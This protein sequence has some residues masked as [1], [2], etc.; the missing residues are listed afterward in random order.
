MKKIPQIL[1]LIGILFSYTITAQVGIGT[2]S[3]HKS[4]IMEV[5][6]SNRGVLIPRVTALQRSNITNPSEGLMVFCT[7]CCG[8]GSLTFFDDT[9]WENTPPCPDLDWDNDGI[10][11]SL[12][13]DD[14][15]DG[16]P[17]GQEEIAR[18]YLIQTFTFQAG[19][20]AAWLDYTGW[21]KNLPID[22]IEVNYYHFSTAINVSFFGGG[23]AGTQHNVLVNNV[24][25]IETQNRPITG[26][27][28]GYVGDYITTDGNAI[29][30]NTTNPNYIVDPQTDNV[31]GLP[32]IKII[33]KVDSTT[34]ILGTLKP[35]DTELVSLQPVNQT[36]NSL[37]PAM[38][39]ANAQ[40]PLP[41]ADV[42]RAGVHKN[43][44]T[45]NTSMKLNF[46]IIYKP[47]IDNDGIVNWKDSDGDGCP[48]VQE[49][50]FSLSAP[51]HGNFIQHLEVGANGMIDIME[52]APESGSSKINRPHPMHATANIFG[53]AIQTQKVCN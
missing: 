45:T 26:L 53:W 21:I 18:G 35:T 39:T 23:A 32:R 25:Y 28:N 41:T 51:P 15:N 38:L 4:A 27:S 3:P 13:V 19:D 10:V 2:T 17:N 20:H 33:F 9:K 44:F 37:T 6:S 24:N 52:S 29:N 5:T 31:N 7:N 30:N 34:Q 48:D 47:D 36:L 14:D 46:Q 11:D 49:N 50:G 16:V 12:D 8:N 43:I 1:F 42:F 22:R 40:S